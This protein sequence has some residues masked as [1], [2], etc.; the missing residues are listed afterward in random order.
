[1]STTNVASI[2]HLENPETDAEGARMEQNPLRI[3]QDAIC[4]FGDPFKDDW[5]YW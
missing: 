3:N 2:V 5:L 1:M 4:E